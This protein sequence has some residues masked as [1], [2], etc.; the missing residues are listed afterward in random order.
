LADHLAKVLALLEFFKLVSELKPAFF[1]AEN[2]PGILGEQYKKIRDKGKKLVAKEYQ[3]LEPLKIAANDFGA[4]TTRTR[5]FFIGIRN[6]ISGA[7]D[8]LKAIEAQKTEHSTF[9]KNALDGLPLEVSED[10][11]DYESSWRKIE[12][13]RSN[14]YFVTLNKVCEGIGDPISI[15]RFLQSKEVSGC[16]GTVHSALVRKRFNKLTQ[17]Q[18]DQTSKM[19]RLNAEGFCPTLR[20]GTDNTKGSYQSVRPIHPFLPRVITPREAARLQ[21]FP[22]WF[23]FHETKWHSFRQIGNS[24][25]PIAA[26]KILSTIR[27]VISK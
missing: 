18:K 1:L 25:C 21:G 16:F 10:W 19:V 11:Q 9:V 24:V 2:V 3:L 5:I 6:D 23:Q 14:E 7:T 22:D 17:G 26:E 12:V 20:A 13:P 15:N 27:D 8:L 4:A